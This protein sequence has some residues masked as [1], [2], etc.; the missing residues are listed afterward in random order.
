MRSLRV[1]CPPLSSRGP[2]A[3]GNPFP[4]PSPGGH[5]LGCCQWQIKP[6]R[7]ARRGRQD[8]SLLCQAKRLPGTASGKVAEHKQGRMRK[9]DGKLPKGI[10]CQT[11]SCA[12]PVAILLL[13]FALQN[14]PYPRE[15]AFFGGSSYTPYGMIGSLRK[16]CPLQRA[17]G[18]I[19]IRGITSSGFLQ[20]QQPRKRS[21]RPWG[22]YLRPGNPSSQHESRLRRLSAYG[23]A[24][25]TMS[26]LK[27]ERM[28]FRNI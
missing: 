17:E 8:A 24:G 6:K 19:T 5:E 7:S 27:I 20:Q 12:G 1:N 21:Y 10:I 3:H 13:S 11:C 14:P 28:S 22:C 26:F 18:T 9:A 4:K 25:R 2:K 23:W 15:R 16:K